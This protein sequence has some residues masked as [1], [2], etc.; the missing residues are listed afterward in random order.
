MPAKIG[1][2]EDHEPLRHAIRSLL[3]ADPRFRVVGEAD[4]EQSTLAMVE[5]DRP[6]MLILDLSLRDGLSMNW[7]RGLV[8]RFPHLH[9]RVV[10]FTVRDDPNLRTRALEAGAGSYV[11]KGLSALE[12]VAAVGE[13][14]EAR[15]DRE[16]S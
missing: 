7:L 1:I 13:L 8:E 4:S 11:L 6:G 5:R 2:V 3:E 12:L 16:G 14:L 10:V 9:G 15:N